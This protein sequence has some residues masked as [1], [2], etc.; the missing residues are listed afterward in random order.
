MTVDLLKIYNSMNPSI[1]DEDTTLNSRVLIVDG[2]NTFIRNFAVNPAMDDEGRHIGGVSGFLKSL[3]FVI[4]QFRPSRVLVVFDGKGG[5]LRRRQMYPQYKD[6]RKMTTRINRAYDLTT[7]QDEQELIKY[8]LILLGKIL[9]NLPINTF[10]YDHVEA[11]DVIAYLTALVSNEGGKSIIYSTDKDFLQLVSNDV[12]VWH[13]IKKKLYTPNDV[14][15]DY[16]IHPNNFL[17]YRSLTGDTSDNIPGIKGMGLK[18]I[19]KH[20]PQLMSE[21]KIT[22]QD[23]IATIPNT[24]SS[25]LNRLITEQKAIELNTKLMRLDDVNISGNT[26]LSI[27]D[28]FNIPPKKFDK[29]SL[30][31]VLIRHKIIQSI[32]NYDSWVITSF[33]PLSKYAI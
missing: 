31:N 16:G 17:L 12:E 2:M 15:E 4:K 32:Q 25:T 9:Q 18:T 30:T 19:Q 27:M 11:D 5:S 22:L 6:N 7:E 1:S 26:K 13:P 8:E 24:K 28:R 14:L 23:M 3:G 29:H 33:E 10:I 20:F 21:E